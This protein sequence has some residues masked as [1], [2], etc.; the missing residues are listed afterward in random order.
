VSRRLVS[1]LILIFVLL[2]CQQPNKPSVPQSLYPLSLGNT[3]TYEVIHRTDSSSYTREFTYS[4]TRYDTIGGYIWSYLESSNNAEGFSR[5]LMAINDSVFELQYS[6][7]GPI[8]ALV[9]LK[10]TH[11]AQN[12]TSLMGGDGGVT[13]TAYLLDSTVV[14]PAGIFTNCYSYELH[15]VDADQLEILAPGVGL[16]EKL[17]Y[18]HPIGE[19]TLLTLITRLKSYHLK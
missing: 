13:K 17:L 10:P 19:D 2:Q 6:W 11:N 5:Y 7:G 1:P 12:F 9:Y 3:W 8:L 4:V 14:T 15:Q 18:I 16:I